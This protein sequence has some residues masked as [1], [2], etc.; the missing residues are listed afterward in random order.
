MNIR[1]VA[2]LMTTPMAATAMTGQV[3]MGAGSAKRW[4]A[5]ETITPTA[6]SSSTALASE[7][8]TVAL[9]RP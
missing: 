8:S 1:A 3:A 5:S 7:A 2:V 4:I 9:R 6:T